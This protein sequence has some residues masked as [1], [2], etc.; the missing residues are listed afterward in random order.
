MTPIQNQKLNLEDIT[1]LFPPV[2]N[3]PQSQKEEWCCYILSEDYQGYSMALYGL[4]SLILH[5][6]RNQSPFP[7]DLASIDAK[8]Q[9]AIE[10]RA[11][12]IQI[13]KYNNY[14]IC[15][16]KLQ[17]TQL[18]YSTTLAGD[19][20]QYETGHRLKSCLK[21]EGAAR[22]A[23][24]SVTFDPVV[25]IGIIPARRNATSRR[26]LPRRCLN[27][28]RRL[29]AKASSNDPCISDWG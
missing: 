8:I 1:P 23:K 20:S 28:L 10:Y 25:D 19:D 6:E 21:I 17:G 5:P 22:R 12:I 27:K 15:T 29:R 2:N 13:I 24:R 18:P 14:N 7:S 16:N 3:I 11:Q 9:E 26:R 4:R